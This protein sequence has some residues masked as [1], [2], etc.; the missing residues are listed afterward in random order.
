VVCCW[1]ALLSKIAGAI[2][3]DL[4]EGGD[5]IWRTSGVMEECGDAAP[6]RSREMQIVVG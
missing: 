6:P 3:E 1:N 4:V 5:E 2:L